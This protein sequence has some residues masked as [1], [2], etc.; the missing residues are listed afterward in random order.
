M[1]GELAAEEGVAEYGFTDLRLIPGQQFSYRVEGF[2]EAGQ[3]ATS[4]AMVGD[5][6]DAMPGQLLLLLVVCVIGLGIYAAIEQFL[7]IQV[8]GRKYSIM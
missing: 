6:L 4:Q 5:S 1:I 8:G 3:L 2:G 7:P